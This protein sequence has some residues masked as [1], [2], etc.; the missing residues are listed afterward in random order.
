MTIIKNGICVSAYIQLNTNVSDA[1]INKTILN[2]QGIDWKG[3]HSDNAN[4]VVSQIIVSEIED[5]IICKYMIYCNKDYITDEDKFK[6][7][8]EKVFRLLAI[9]KDFI[10]RFTNCEYHA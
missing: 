2:I 3:I 4:L 9:K 10:I 8:I 6:Q 7:D 5:A 1:I